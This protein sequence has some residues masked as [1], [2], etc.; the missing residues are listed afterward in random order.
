[1]IISC[2]RTQD[3]DLVIYDLVMGGRS[4]APSTN[5]ML[6]ATQI[7]LRSD[8]QPSISLLEQLVVNGHIKY[9]DS[10][11]YITSPPRP[12]QP[13][14]HPGKKNDS[15]LLLSRLTYHKRTLCLSIVL[16]T[17]EVVSGKLILQS[18]FT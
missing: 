16:I 7:N 15:L 18:G 14:I 17:R 2:S 3:Y 5:L 6:C 9:I 11:P 12:P 8:S 4:L 1:M 10:Y 13:N